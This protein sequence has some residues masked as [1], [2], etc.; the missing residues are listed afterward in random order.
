MPDMRSARTSA[1]PAEH[2]DTRNLPG[3]STHEHW[4]S[5]SKVCPQCKTCNFRALKIPTE[6]M[7][8]P[9]FGNFCAIR[10]GEG[11][12]RTCFGLI[13]A[14]CCE[15]QRC[16]SSTTSQGM[17]SGARTRGPLNVRSEFQQHARSA[18]FP[19]TQLAP[20]CQAHLRNRSNFVLVDFRLSLEVSDS[21]QSAAP[22][23]Q[24]DLQTLA[25]PHTILIFEETCAH[26][27]TAALGAFSQSI[28]V[29]TS[30][31]TLGMAALTEALSETEARV[32]VCNLKDP[33]QTR[34][35]GGS[36]WGDAQIWRRRRI[37]DSPQGPRCSPAPWMAPTHSP[38]S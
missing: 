38:D 35:P 34:P 12:R 18:I 32:I 24:A 27:V 6:P 8:D 17:R 19:A 30:Y 1:K 10:R 2:L 37:G 23:P 25:G 15:F 7:F 31:A 36:R 14:F 29:A 3:Q 26:W 5:R 11:S 9:L 22:R 33:A 16:A 13:L 28:A 4:P 20:P 21:A